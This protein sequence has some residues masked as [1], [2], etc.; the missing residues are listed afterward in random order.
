[1]LILVSPMAASAST[2]V[3]MISASASAAIMADQLDTGLG[4]LALRLQVR[5]ADAQALPG[6]GQPQRGAVHRQ[7]VWQPA[8]AICGVVSARRPIM[9]WLSGSISRKVCSAV[10]APEPANRLSSNSSNGG[11][12]R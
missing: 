2:A 6:V 12:T 11:F 8:G 4:N 5:A 9:R 7:D 10:A 3:K 1:M